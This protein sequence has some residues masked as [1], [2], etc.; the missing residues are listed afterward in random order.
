MRELTIQDKVANK[1]Y[2]LSDQD[3]EIVLALMDRI[4]DLYEDDEDPITDEEL[5]AFDEAYEHRNDPNYWT[6]AEDLKKEL[7]LC[8]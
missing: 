6:S 3:S 2:S 1:A 5:K 4:L 7:E 8:E